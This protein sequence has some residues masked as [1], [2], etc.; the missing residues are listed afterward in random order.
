MKKTI[1]H[2]EQPKVLNTLIE[3]LAQAAGGASQLVHHHQDP[4]FVILRTAI[5]EARDMCIHI[6]TINASKITRVKPT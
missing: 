5:D 6:A 2:A 4:R 1:T 3:S